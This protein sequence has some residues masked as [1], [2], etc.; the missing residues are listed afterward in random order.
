MHKDIDILLYTTPTPRG[1][2]P[3]IFLEEA[4]IRYDV[5][6]V[7]LIKNEQKDP[8]YLKLNPHGKVPIII[9][10]SNDN[11]V[12]FE[13]SAIL[14]YLA[15][16][17]NQFI[18]V[19]AKNKSLCMQWLMFQTS[20]IELMM[21]QAAYF[22]YRVNVADIKE[23]E[24]KFAIDLYTSKSRNLCEVLDS[25]LKNKK[26]L[27]KEDYTIA[28][29]AINPWV[30]AYEFLGI[31][32]DGLDNLQSWL[33]RIDNREATQRALS[34]PQPPRWDFFKKTDNKY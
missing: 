22:L 6:E 15:E 4:G 29:M 3:V 24:H 34:I 26:Y 30:R 12:V 1:W 16:K 5:K 10:K 25:S 32:I 20:S 21:G 9:D 18:P 19:D 17:Y 14:W 7:D 8:E 2:K 33:E 31:S 11:F 27:V 13:S 23:K 28:D